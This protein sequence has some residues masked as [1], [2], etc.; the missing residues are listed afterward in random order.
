M[1]VGRFTDRRVAGRELA[2]YLT[3]YAERE[4]VIVLGLPRGGIP[5]AYRSP[6]H[7][8]RHWMRYLVRSLGVPGRKGLAFGVSPAAACVY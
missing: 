6:P 5:V 7:S 3:K 1:R 4:D 2:E 8:R